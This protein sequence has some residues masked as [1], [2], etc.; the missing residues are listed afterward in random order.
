MGADTGKLVMEVVEASHLKF[1][2]LCE[3]V[4]DPWDICKAKIKEK[5]VEKKAD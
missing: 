1:M 2:N 5:K 4:R 3:C